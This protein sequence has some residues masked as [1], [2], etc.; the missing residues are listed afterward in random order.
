MSTCSTSRQLWPQYDGSRTNLILGLPSHRLRIFISVVTGHWIVGAHARRL[1]LPFNDF[2][3]SCND[4]EEEETVEHFL[5]YCPT[6][7]GIRTAK[8]GSPFMHVLSDLSAIDIRKINSFIHAS[9]WFESNVNLD[10]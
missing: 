1:G 2:C 10:M 4:E 7:S 5:C 6:L 8:L 3:R 9:G